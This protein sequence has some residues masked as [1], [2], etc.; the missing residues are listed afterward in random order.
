MDIRSRFERRQ[1]RVDIPSHRR[2][3]RKTVPRQRFINGL[4]A[5]VADRARSVA[6]GAVTSAHT[7]KRAAKD[8]QAG[9]CQRHDDVP[10][11]V[12]CGHHFYYWFK[13]ESQQLQFSEDTGTREA[14]CAWWY[15]I[16]P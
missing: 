4:V 14:W 5:V 13:H 12:I 6:T 8:Q 9:E 3:H 10:N 7:S 16:A 1:N 11:M 2:K 15:R